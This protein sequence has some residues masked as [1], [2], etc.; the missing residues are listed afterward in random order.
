MQYQ[1]S[2]EP[3]KIGPYEAILREALATD[4]RR[5]RRERRMAR[6][7][8]AQLTAQ[9]FGQLWTRPSPRGLTLRLTVSRSGGHDPGRA[10]FHRLSSLRP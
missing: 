1:R 2:A 10:G 9:G 5:P 7:L 8:H 6:K 4:A 3:K